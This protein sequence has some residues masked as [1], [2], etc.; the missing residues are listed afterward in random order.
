[1]TTSGY[2]LAHF[3]VHDHEVGCPEVV[4]GRGPGRRLR[5]ELGLLPRLETQDHGVGR[6]LQVEL[7]LT[8]GTLFDGDPLVLGVVPLDDRAIWAEDEALTLEAGR[9]VLAA[10]V[11]EGFEVCIAKL[12]WHLTA[13][14]HPGGSPRRA[15]RLADL[16]GLVGQGE[17]V[18][19]GDRF[20]LTGNARDGADGCRSWLVGQRGHLDRQRR[21][22][23]WRRGVASRR[24]TVGPG[25]RGLGRGH[26]WEV[27]PFKRG[28]GAPEGLR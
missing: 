17:A 27:F 19:D 3:I 24:A 7:D 2:Q 23:S 6:C 9:V 14:P 20:P 5:T 13:E 28:I 26:A 21:Q 4:D 25:R 10:E 12:L 15:P 1:M 8:V 18:R 22:P 16:E 11:D